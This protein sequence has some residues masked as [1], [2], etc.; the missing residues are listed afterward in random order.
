M[1][2]PIFIKDS[3]NSPL[4]VDKLKFFDGQVGITICP[5]KYDDLARSGP[6]HRDVKKDLTLAKDWGAK[7]VVT[8]LEDH[9]IEYLRVQHMPEVIQELGLSWWRSPVPDGHALEIPGH[10]FLD[11]Q[12]DHW[13]LPNALIRRFLKAGGKVLIHCRGGLGRTGTLVSRLL[14]EEGYE[15][16]E[17]IAKVREA[18][19]GS[20]ENGQQVD[21]LLDLPRRLAQKDRLY[22][23]LAA[24]PDEAQNQPIQTL[25]ADPLKFD[26]CQWRQLVK[27]LLPK[28]LIG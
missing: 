8:L 1:E 25:F 20:V 3:D 24:I 9:E 12:Y 19:R 15:P 4:R 27:T 6:T 22:A 26:L 16:R 2:T 13:T 7:L 28:D 11:P 17:A 14:I 5:G 21:Y 18:R 10:P 23:A